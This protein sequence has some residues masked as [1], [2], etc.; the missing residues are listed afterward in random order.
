MKRFILFLAVSFLAISS[1]A[2]V[3]HAINF[4]AIAR[5]AA[6]DV[7]VNTPIQIRLTIIDG[8]ATGTDVYQEL[9]ALTTSGYGSFS[10]Q[11]GRNANFVT[12]GN[13]DNINWNSGNKFLKIDYDP[14]NQFNWSLTLGTIEF[15]SVPFALSAENVSFIDASNAQNGDVLKFNSVTGKFEPGTINTTESDPIFVASPAYGITNSNITDWN[16]A[17]SWGNHADAGYQP[18]ITVGDV[19]LYWRGDKTWQTLNNSAVGLGYVENIALSAWTGSAN[20]NTL[21]NVTTG[22][23]NAGD[24]SSS[25][26]VTGNT[27]VKTGGTA[28]Q[29]LKA[30]GSVDGNTYLTAIREVADEYIAILA[31]TNFTLTQIPSPNSKVKMYIN[32]IRI[33][34]TAYNVSGTTLTYNSANN[35]SNTLTA[36]DRIQLDY[37]Y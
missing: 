32:G 6:G 36:G 3:P 27:I 23:W 8:S 33:S 21:G 20:I 19:S 37:Y 10:F 13:I 11:I 34:N 5:N 26:V 1:F 15:V 14:T 28:S 29:F 25:G 2:Q 24:V 12:I 31:Q 18:L 7:M 22:T 30:D 9:R 17:Y 4:Q 35:G 16:S